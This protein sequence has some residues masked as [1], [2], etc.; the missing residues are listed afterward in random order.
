MRVTAELVDALPLLETLECASLFDKARPAL[1]CCDSYLVAPSVPVS[2]AFR[3]LWLNAA[4]LNAALVLSR[5]IGETC[6]HSA[7]P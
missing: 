2:E 1:L 4:E 5:L 6:H 7:L 3:A